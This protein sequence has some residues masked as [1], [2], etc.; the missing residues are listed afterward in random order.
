MI[1]QW[2]SK[3]IFDKSTNKL[4]RAELIGKNKNN[5]GSIYQFDM[6]F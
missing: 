4:K 1:F 3:E 2:P 5:N 6:Q